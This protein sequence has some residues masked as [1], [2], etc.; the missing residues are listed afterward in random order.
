MKQSH[1]ARVE[2]DVY[3]STWRGL[4][5]ISFLL[6][7]LF[8]T[9]KDSSALLALVTASSTV[10][11]YTS[12]THPVPKREDLQAINSIK[13]GVITN[14]KSVATEIEGALSVWGSEVEKLKFRPC[15]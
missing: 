9:I 11:L 5:R 4:T 12:S 8:G 2:I 15:H 1:S 13:V 7:L 3:K 14:S 10:M 6:L